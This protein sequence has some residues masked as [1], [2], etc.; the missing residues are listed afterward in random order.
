[1]CE[2]HFI[3]DLAH[4]RRQIFRGTLN[5]RMV[6]GGTWAAELYEIWGGN[7]TI[8]ST[9][10][11]GF[12]LDFRCLSLFRNA[13]GTTASPVDTGVEFEFRTL[14]VVLS[15]ILLLIGSEL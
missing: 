8:I 6:L 1:M 13:G 10:I 15:A 14:C 2:R 11:T 3:D 9:R 12:G 7:R 4:F 5:L